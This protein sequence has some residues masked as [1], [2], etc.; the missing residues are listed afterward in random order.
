MSTINWNKYSYTEI[1]LREAVKNNR[2]ARAAM[3]AVGLSGEGAGYKPFMRLVKLLQ[4]D[5]SHWTG[6]AYLKGK[7]HAYTSPKKLEE[8]LKENTHY[9]SYKLGKRLVR[10]G[11]VAKLCSNCGI[12]EWQG[13]ELSLHLDHI[14]GDNEDNR[15]ENLRLLCPNCHSLTNTYCGKNKKLNRIKLGKTASKN[16]FTGKCIDCQKPVRKESK[17]C[18]PCRNETLKLSKIGRTTRT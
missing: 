3:M 18:K 16:L 10:E 13:Q 9:Q 17:R 7:R 6:Q 15:L 11:L 2:S 8:I 14:N 12:I 4:L 1:D 5:T